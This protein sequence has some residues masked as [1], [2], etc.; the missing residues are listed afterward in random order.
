MPTVTDCC[1]SGPR[2]LNICGNYVIMFT[3]YLFANCR[4]LFQQS[5]QFANIEEKYN[6]LQQEAEKFLHVENKVNLI[7]EKVIINILIG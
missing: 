5:N 7:S 1:E 3:I 6:F 2:T 4:F